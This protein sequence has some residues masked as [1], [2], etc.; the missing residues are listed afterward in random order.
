MVLD[1]DRA[2]S[3]RVSEQTRLSIPGCKRGSPG[4]TE[5]HTA[6]PWNDAAP[7]ESVEFPNCCGVHIHPKPVENTCGPVAGTHGDVLTVHTEA[8]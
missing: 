1:F 3:E 8:F 6:V 7:Q 5:H 2:A 4:A